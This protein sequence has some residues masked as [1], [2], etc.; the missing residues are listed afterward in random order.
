MLPDN[1]ACRT[2]HAREQDE[3]A[4]PAYRV[5]LE[6][7]AVR[8]QSAHHHAA[9]CRM[10][11]DFPLDINKRTDDHTEQGGDDDAA[12]IAGQVIA[13]HCDHASDIA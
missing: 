4:E 5:E 13:V 7:E 12:H 6:D 8:E 10:S 1:D 9:T 11:A 2:Q 3:G